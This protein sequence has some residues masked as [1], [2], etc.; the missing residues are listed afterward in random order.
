MAG[1][2]IE[3]IA[4]AKAGIMKAKRPVVI[5]E[6]PY[7]EALR[8]LEWHAKQLD[9]P[10]IRPHNLIRLTA[11]QTLQEGHTMVQMVAAE[12]H[13]LTWLQ[14]TG[15]VCCPCVYAVVANG[16]QSTVHVLG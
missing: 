5:A 7:S 8:V 6:Q 15:T 10:V 9:C 11:K 4:E 2:S 3:A 12:P 13:G 16:I 1:G 14:P